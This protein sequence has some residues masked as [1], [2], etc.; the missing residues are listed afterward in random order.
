MKNNY[1]NIY[2]IKLKMTCKN[3]Q[4]TLLNKRIGSFS[5]KTGYKNA[6]IENKWQDD[7]F[8]WLEIIRQ[9]ERVFPK[10]P[11]IIFTTNEK[12]LLVETKEIIRK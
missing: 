12:H 9:P 1:K 2:E 3:V 11:Q 4:I 6:R 10:K 5:A 7:I 8:W